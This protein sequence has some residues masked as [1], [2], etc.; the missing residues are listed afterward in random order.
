MIA[1]P[2]RDSWQINSLRAALLTSLLATGAAVGAPGDLDSLFGVGGRTFINMDSNAE[3]ATSLVQQSDG[4]L[5]VG[6]ATN[7]M[8]ATSVD[9]SVVRLDQDG[10]LDLSF[11]G[12]GMASTD[13]P[14]VTASTRVV[15]QLASGKIAVVGLAWSDDYEG[16]LF[17]T[18]AR[19]L[20][21]GTLDTAFGTGGFVHA[22][23]GSARASIL[24]VVEQPDGR[25]VAAGYVETTPGAG[26]A[27]FTR[28]NLDGSVDTTFGH[29]GRLILDLNGTKNAEAAYA[30]VQR[31]DGGLISAVVWDDATS[32]ARTALVTMTANGDLESPSGLQVRPTEGIA[33]GRTL[34]RPALALQSD[35]KVVL[36]GV[37]LRPDSFACDLHIERRDA[38]GHLDPTFGA[39][40]IATFALGLCYS[41]VD[42]IVASDDSILFSGAS[43]RFDG[44]WD[45][46]FFSCPCYPLVLRVTANGE[47]DVTFGMD[48]AA[49]IDLGVGVLQSNVSDIE[50]THVLQQS[51]GRIVIAASGQYD[52][53]MFS[54]NGVTSSSVGIVLSRLLASGAS[55]GLI[56]FKGAGPRFAESVQR[57]SARAAHRWRGG[58]RERAVRNVGWFGAQRVRL[59]VQQ[60]HA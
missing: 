4:K 21:D 10:R 51:D 45:Y 50:G 47:R 18:I 55:P 32:F 41:P 26:D 19:Y 20:A 49:S 35:G 39:S 5:L 23:L 57:R 25:L 1:I 28:F 31:P 16:R 59:Q 48:G 54:S 53:E 3:A 15:L 36:A 38:S 44:E 42:I 14:G 17:S 11:G 56:G 7:F 52:D 29:G 6:R 34:D 13:L 30:L 37:V 58:C 8:V 43:E 22:D 46:G 24:A 12:D 2:R 60:R 9:L 33:Y 27:A 40:G